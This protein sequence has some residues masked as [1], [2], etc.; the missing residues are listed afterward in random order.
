MLCP[1]EDPQPLQDY[2]LTQKAAFQ[3]CMLRK[4]E[5]IT[6]IIYVNVEL[7]A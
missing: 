3:L 5:G 6:T 4:P 1:V 2:L 7:S